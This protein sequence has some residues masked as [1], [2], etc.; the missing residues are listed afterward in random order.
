MKK[1]KDILT[2]GQD[3][4]TAEETENLPEE[5][6]AGKN[7][8]SSVKIIPLGGLDR[9]GM[10][11]T[12]FESG[13]EIIVVDAGI[14]FP[15][16]DMPGVEVIVPDFSYLEEN[17]EKVSGLILTHGHEDH[18]GAV[19]YLLKKVPCA[20]YGTRLTLGIVEGKLDEFDI[21]SDCLNEV[22]AGEVVEFRNFEV[23][24]IHVNHS[25]PDSA[26]LAIRTPCG[27]VVMTGDFKIDH[28]P[29]GTTPIDLPRF[30]D[31]GRE[32]VHL[33]MA[34]STNV[35][36]PG[37]TP[38]DSTLTHSFDRIFAETSKRIIFST[39][40]SNVHRIQQILNA[41]EKWN[42]KVAVTG[43]SMQ[44]VISAA[45]QLGYL[46]IPDGV[47]IDI[48]D[49]KRFR[50]KEL[51]ILTTGT[52]GEPMSALHRMAFGLHGQ[53][54]L[55]QDDLVILSASCIPGNERFVNRIINELY[56][57]KVTVITD[58]TDDVHVSGH[59]CR[60]ELKLMHSLLCADNFIP[61][62][63][64]YRHLAQHAQ[65]AKDLGMTSSHILIP[66]I[67][68]VVVMDKKGIHAGE[69]I[70]MYPV[71]IDS[72][73]I[74]GLE[75]VVLTERRKLM[76]AGIL[77]VTCFMDL[78]RQLLFEPDLI[79]RGFVFEKESAELLDDLRSR[80]ADAV[81]RCLDRGIED[82]KAIE[83]KMKEEL[84]AAVYEKTKRRP[85]IVA[86]M[87]FLGE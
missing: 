2:A 9:I 70:E 4:L 68:R 50:S 56:R 15:Q 24:F 53:I 16:D 28:T 43:R 61:V 37:F 59:A 83:K 51:T 20:V 3:P 67:G 1:K 48:S 75:T 82:E 22:S 85:M 71:M 29:I 80:V 25:M 31:L 58:R 64:E 78:D 52:Q 41:S 54:E 66:E 87:R 32:G 39:F 47:M 57:R 74:N 19:P 17:R 40:A 36:R 79:T 27:T 35:E 81:E 23:E 34:D 69:S 55:G 45:Y 7:A 84:S 44:N 86:Q 18:I 10:N 26:A 6:A 42:R 77:V 73:N 46:N 60:E 5:A 49:T 72:G 8:A 12:V 21:P 11:C 65:L 14:A 76:E 38:S 30:A 33:L 13:G 62:H 63:G